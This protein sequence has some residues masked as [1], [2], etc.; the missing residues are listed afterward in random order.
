MAT[1]Y[2]ISDLVSN[3][4]RKRPQYKKRDT[5]ARQWQCAVKTV[6]PV[7]TEGFAS[8]IAALETPHLYTA[9]ALFWLCKC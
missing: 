2:S 6:H 1:L 9:C 5:K 4:E 8:Q 3:E 7:D